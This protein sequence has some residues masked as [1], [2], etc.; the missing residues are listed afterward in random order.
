M[1]LKIYRY[2]LL[3]SLIVVL[4]FNV[5]FLTLDIIN[6][7]QHGA[8]NIFDEIMY[9]LCL[10]L[11]L[12]FIGLQI[13]NTIISFKKGSMFIK[14]LAYNDDNS[15]NDRFLKLLGIADVILFVLVIY[16]ILLYCGVSLPLKD[17]SQAIKSIMVTFI[18]ILFIDALFILLFPL[19]GKDDPAFSKAKEKK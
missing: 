5:L 1:K 8:D 15:L 12:C 3:S 14:N 6:L 18:S 10:L 13:Y 4:G 9:I 16:S 11:S 19:L 2:T 17:L 7:I